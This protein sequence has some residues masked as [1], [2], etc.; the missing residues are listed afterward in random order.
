VSVIDTATNSVVGG[1]ISVG[2][3]SYG[4]AVSPDGQLVYVLSVGGASV[5]V[6]DTA[7]NSVVG[8]PLSVRSASG[9][10]VS[11]DG[12]HIYVTSPSSRTVTVISVVPITARA[13]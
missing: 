13:A 1:P 12:S 6:I 3:S 7:A 10:V 5:S 8:S 2:P 11:P 9:M 4:I